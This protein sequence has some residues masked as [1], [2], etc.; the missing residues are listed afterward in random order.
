MKKIFPVLVMV[1]V[2]LLSCSKNTDTANNGTPGGGGGTTTVDCTSVKKS[3]S[4]DV[5][6]IIQ[7]SCALAGCH[8]AGSLNG[9]GELT[10]YMEVFNARVN[11][12]SAVSSGIMP[13]T[14]TLTT[15]QKNSILCWIDA[16]ASNN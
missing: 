8:I 5:L 11:I 16:G 9:P 7:N 3:F 6:P 15:A 1:P 13:K 14:G 12:R 2:L 10:N 4:A